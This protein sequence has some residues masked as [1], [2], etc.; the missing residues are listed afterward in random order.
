MI[1][2]GRPRLHYTMLISFCLTL[3]AGLYFKA[4]LHNLFTDL[5]LLRKCLLVIVDLH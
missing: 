1:A 3:V 4:M 5:T 2:E